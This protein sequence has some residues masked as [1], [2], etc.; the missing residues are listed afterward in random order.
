M[1]ILLDSMIRKTS[2]H[3]RQVEFSPASRPNA[4]A[5]D[6]HQSHS[7]VSLI[8]PL[9]APPPRVPA[10][11]LSVPPSLQQGKTPLRDGDPWL[12]AVS[13][14]ARGGHPRMVRVASRAH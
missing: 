2:Q 3:L 6:A 7:P 11:T 13:A 8:H 1:H 4:L 14:T 12:C 10:R 9:A 5:R